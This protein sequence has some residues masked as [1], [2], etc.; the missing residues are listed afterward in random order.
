[1]P[2]LNTDIE[3]LLSRTNLTSPFGEFL[4]KLEEEVPRLGKIRNLQPILEGY[5]D[6]NFILESDLG[7]LV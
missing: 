3:N 1:M 5:E 6:A 2:N 7:R 4:K